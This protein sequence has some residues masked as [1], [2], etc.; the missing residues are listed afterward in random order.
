MLLP[1]D[2]GCGDRLML[3]APVLGV[4]ASVAVSMPA[5]LM[6]RRLNESAVRLQIAF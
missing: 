6:V 4:N 1:W 2:P 5:L 3:P